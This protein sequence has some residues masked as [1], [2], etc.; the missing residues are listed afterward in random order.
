MATITL[1]LG[2]GNDPDPVVPTSTG[3]ITIDTPGDTIVLTGTDVRL[4]ILAAAIGR[5]MGVGA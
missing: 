4:E 3:Q 1:D 5:A 2:W